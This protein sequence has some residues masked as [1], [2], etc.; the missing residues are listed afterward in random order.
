[1][2]KKIQ[3]ESGI[4]LSKGMDIFFIGEKLPMKVM[5]VNEKFAIC[6]RKLHRKEDLNLLRERVEMRAYLSVSEAYSDLKKEMVYTIIDLK[7]NAKGPD[8]YGGYCGYKDQEEIEEVLSLLNKGEIELSRRKAVE[9]NLDFERTLNQKTIDKPKLELHKNVYIVDGFVYITC[10]EENKYQDKDVII[11]KTEEGRILYAKKVLYS[12][13]P[14]YQKLG[15]SPLLKKHLNWLK[16]NELPYIVKNENIETKSIDKCDWC[17][18]KMYSQEDLE[19]AFYNG[20]IY[21]AENYTF[22]KAK[23]EWLEQLKKQQ[24]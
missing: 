14:K 3:T 17:G 21:K 23:K 16:K 7:N 4:Q 18:K 9:Y 6:T 12:N 1:M 24:Q 22:P 2:N 15:V 20:W 13:N 10:E 8:N 5:A 19:N 11:E